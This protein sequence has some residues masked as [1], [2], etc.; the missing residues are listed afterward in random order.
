MRHGALSACG[1]HF[2]LAL[3]VLLLFL[4]LPCTVAAACLARSGAA[5]A[6]LV[7][8][9]SGERCTACAEAERRLAALRPEAAPEALLAFVLFVDLG[10][11]PGASQDRSRHR[12]KL[13]LQQ[14][15][16]LVY[17][18]Q[19]LVQGRALE[20]PF[21]HRLAPAVAAARSR[22]PGAHLALQI[23]GMRPGALA[24]SVEAELEAGVPQDAAALYLAP[25]SEE[26]AGRVVLAWQGPYPFAARRLQLAQEA[27]LAPG[28]DAARA[29]AAAF[30][31][32]R[33]TGEV[34]QALAR[35]AC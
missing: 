5:T 24:L 1:Y 3:S 19:A 25:F 2:E 26:E 32:N 6:V 28:T 14:R 20:H 10:A 33:R 12:R 18:P 29:G 35:P 27:P 21:L 23:T 31:Q 30:V 13:T 4:L 9:Y 22:A 34:L 7:E 16:A 15:L 11:Y 8:L 17:T